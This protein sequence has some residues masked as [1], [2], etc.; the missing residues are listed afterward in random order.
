MR[1]RKLASLN[2][3]W[4]IILAWWPG[5]GGKIG[6]GTRRAMQRIEI[7]GHSTIN[8]RICIEKT[9]TT[10]GRTASRRVI[11]N[12]KEPIARADWH[13]TTWLAE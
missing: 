6:K 1:F 11:D 8:W 13:E 5:A 10:I 7:K 2:R 12:E 9:T 3:Y 4:Q